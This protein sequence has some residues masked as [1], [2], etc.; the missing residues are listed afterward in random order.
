M[1]KY[2]E[3]ACLLMYLY[4]QNRL[5]VVLDASPVCK[6]FYIDEMIISRIRRDAQCALLEFMFLKTILGAAY[7]LTTY[8]HWVPPIVSLVVSCKSM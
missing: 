7:A 5:E 6:A 1:R 8:I 2:K 3:E 4:S